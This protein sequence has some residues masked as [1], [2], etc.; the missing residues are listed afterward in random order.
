[1]ID[2]LPSR[3]FEKSSGRIH[4]DYGRSA[5]RRQ[6]R[7]VA[8]AAPEIEHALRGLRGSPL[9]HDARHGRQLGGRALVAAQAP[10]KARRS[11][12]SLSHRR[13][14]VRLRAVYLTPALREG[15]PARGASP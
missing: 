6:Q 2:R 3:H 11:S 7:R 5:R 1:V 13:S 14:V 9:D 15:D 10:V 4:S 12:A 8:R